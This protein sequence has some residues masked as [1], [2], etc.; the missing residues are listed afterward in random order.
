MGIVRTIEVYTLLTQNVRRKRNLM[1][2]NIKQIINQSA[3][4]NSL[5]TGEDAGPG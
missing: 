1:Y 2:A 5:I 3:I 4:D